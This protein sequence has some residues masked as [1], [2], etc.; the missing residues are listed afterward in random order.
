M[1]TV[2]SSRLAV[3]YSTKEDGDDGLIEVCA[4]KDAQETKKIGYDN[5]NSSNAATCVM[6]QN[7]LDLQTFHHIGP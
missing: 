3:H 4:L 1:G 5:N 2:T 7:T 6:F